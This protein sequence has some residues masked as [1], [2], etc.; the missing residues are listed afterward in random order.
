MSFVCVLRRFHFSFSYLQS[1][2]SSSSLLLFFFSLSLS[3]FVACD[4][5]YSSDCHRGIFTHTHTHTHTK[6]GDSASQ[7]RDRRRTRKRE[8]IGL[9]YPYHALL[10]LPAGVVTLILS[11][12]LSL[13]PSVP[14]S[15]LFRCCFF[16]CVFGRFSVPSKSHLF[17]VNYSTV[18]DWKYTHFRELCCSVQ[19]SKLVFFFL[20]SFLFFLLPHHTE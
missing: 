2:S 17:R 5:R 8:G 11:G 6:E 12:S 16:S 3:H 1:L 7:E 10:Q 18:I 19:S 20:F 9:K 4:V 14:L 15:L 13:S